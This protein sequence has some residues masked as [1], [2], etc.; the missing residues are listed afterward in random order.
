MLSKLSA[1]A[2]KVDFLALSDVLL[3]LH[4]F[5]SFLQLTSNF[6]ICIMLVGYP[7]FRYLQ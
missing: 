7:H 4:R 5:F 6:L 3:F 2:Q 1:I